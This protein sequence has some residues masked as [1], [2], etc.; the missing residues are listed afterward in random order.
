MTDL[1]IVNTTPPAEKE[2]RVDLADDWLDQIAEIEQAAN[3]L[4]GA[5]E[6]LQAQAD[7]LAFDKDAPED[8]REAATRV[9]NAAAEVDYEVGQQLDDLRLAGAEA[10]REARV[11]HMASIDPTAVANEFLN[12][13]EQ[14]HA[15]EVPDYSA[16]M[17][18][19]ATY[20][21]GVSIEYAQ[22]LRDALHAGRV[23]RGWPDPQ[24]APSGRMSIEPTI[25][26]AIM[27]LWLC[28]LRSCS[29]RSD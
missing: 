11:A 5:A 12:L 4:A 20:T 18:K 2:D 6:D 10:H 16:L 17:Q 21:G 22:T 24:P 29:P 1:A 3:R 13:W 15:A 26:G 9:S 27:G 28:A 14:A 7:A 19:F 23:A 25:E 8:L